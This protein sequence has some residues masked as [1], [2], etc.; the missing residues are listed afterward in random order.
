MVPELP[1]EEATNPKL[2]AYKKQTEARL[3]QGART[4]AALKIWTAAIGVLVPILTMAGSA[5][6]FLVSRHDKVAPQ[7]QQM[8]T[9]QLGGS[10]VLQVV[11][12]KSDGGQ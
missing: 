6:A 3:V 5:I 10:I 7:S 1:P 2:A 4:M 8:P 9:I 11:P 12:P